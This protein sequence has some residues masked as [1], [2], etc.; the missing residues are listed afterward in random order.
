MSIPKKKILPRKTV[1]TSEIS[2]TSDSQHSTSN[3]I[4]YTVKVKVITPAQKKRKKKA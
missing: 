3:P 2:Y 1:K 4:N